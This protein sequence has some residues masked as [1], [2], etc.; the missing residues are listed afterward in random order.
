MK[1][2]IS[3]FLI[4]IL[5]FGVCLALT[6]CG[7]PVVNV[8]SELDISPDFAG[9]RTVD[10]VYP[11]N[12]NI[13]AIKDTL[14]NNAPTA[15]IN[16]AEF[17]Y[18]GVAEDG[19][20]FELKLTFNGRDKYEEEVS[21]LLGRRVSPILSQKDTALTKGTRMAEDFDVSELIGWVVRDTT[22]DNNTKNITFDYNRNT[23]RIGN[24]EYKTSSTV[25]INDCTGSQI[26]SVSIKTSNDKEGGYGRTFVFTVPNE[27]YKKD[28]EAVEQYFLTNTSPVA[29]YSGWSAEGTNMVYTV[30]FSGLSMDKLT[31]V[32]SM[33]LDTDSTEIFYGD[34]DNASTPLSEGLSFEETLDTFSFIGADNGYPKLEYSYSL[35]T[36]TIHGD[37]SVFEDGRWV[38]KGSWEDGVYKLTLEAGAGKVRIPDGIQYSINGINFY[39]ESLGDSRFRRSTEFLYSKTDGHDG[40]NYADKFFKGKGVESSTGENED[41]LFCRVVSEGTVDEITD[42]LV[43]LFGSGNFMAY[44]QTQGGLSLTVKTEMTDYVNLGYMLNS[45]N[46]NRPMTYYVSSD[47]GDNIVSVSV[48]GS[49]TA[50]TDHSSSSLPVKGGCAVV[51]YH[52]NIPIVS[53][54]IIY[55][56]VGSLLLVLTA[57]VC[58]MLLK[59]KKRRKVADPL[60][61]PEA[62][63]DDEAAAAEAQAEN[64]PSK[65]SL[66]QTTTFSIFE[67]NALSRNKKYVDEINKD[68]EQRIHEDSLRDQKNDIRA[69][70]LKEMSRRVYGSDE[71]EKPT[72]VQDDRESSEIQQN[73]SEDNDNDQDGSI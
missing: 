13:D 51:E 70:E 2:L 3:L 20:H 53:H 15:D 25:D 22:A 68:I 50:Y 18:T 39:L 62:Y 58:I 33:L 14:V 54:I 45:S 64:D 63:T 66:A 37:G 10:V 35:P 59:P 21:A 32:T 30:I 52:G 69:R 47:H 67:L 40:M 19:Y 57:F 17:T 4:I 9:T 46:A 71:E 23:V 41:N 36:N 73:Q 7:G 44:R 55:V 60:N 11:L 72:D 6:G 38:S 5:C 27:T 34:R 61:N 43:K 1:R 65:N 24:S 48:D 16:G 56:V 49:E 29:E 28:Q 31:E 8:I 12:V 26:N 42:E